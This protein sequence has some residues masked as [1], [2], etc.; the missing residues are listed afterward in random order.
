MN[1][2]FF[3]CDYGWTKRPN[4][5]K[6]RLPDIFKTA[7]IFCALWANISCAV[8]SQT[9]LDHWLNNIPMQY[10]VPAWSTQPSSWTL[11]LSHRPTFLYKMLAQTEAATGGFLFLEISQNSQENT[12]TRVSFSIKL[13][14]SGLQFYWKRD[15]GTGVF[16]GV[17][18]YL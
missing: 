5:V 9:Y 17:L 13:Q 15:P 2:S 12:C 3:S 7:G 14:S 18:R 10:V 11:Y 1:Q 6:N 16:L 4:I 8:L